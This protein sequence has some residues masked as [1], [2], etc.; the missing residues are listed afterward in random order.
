[1]EHEVA[2]RDAVKCPDLFRGRTV[3]DTATESHGVRALHAD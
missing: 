2:I 1:M 3:Y